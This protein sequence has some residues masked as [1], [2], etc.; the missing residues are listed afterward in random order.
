MKDTITIRCSCGGTFEEPVIGFEDRPMNQYNSG[1]HLDH[2]RPYNW[3]EQ[4]GEELENW[5][6]ENEG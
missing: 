4:I 1:E 5:R 3:R 6:R 2:R